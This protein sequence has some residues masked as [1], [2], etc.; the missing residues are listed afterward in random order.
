MKGYKRNNDYKF[1][2]PYTMIP[3]GLETLN[4]IDKNQC[5]IKLRKIIRSISELP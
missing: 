2:N 1:C 4:N 5:F 3:L